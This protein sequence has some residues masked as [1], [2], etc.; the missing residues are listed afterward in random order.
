[1][2]R[3]A[4][5][6][7]LPLALLLPVIGCSDLANGDGDA[8]VHRDSRPV[9]HDAAPGVDGS[10]TCNAA[11]LL[12]QFRCGPGRQ[13]TLVS[14]GNDVGCAPAGA[15]GAYGSCDG[16]QDR[17]DDCG[18]GTLCSD[19]KT[20]GT[21]QCLPFCGQQ[22]AYCE[23][24]LCVFSVPLPGSETAYLCGP[25]DGCDALNSGECP[26]GQSCYLAPIGQDMTFCRPTGGIADGAPCTGDFTC[27]EGLTCFGPPDD[28]TCHWLCDIQS[29]WGCT[30]SQLCG[31]MGSERYGICF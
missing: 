7:V 10:T 2:L 25:A 26:L 28:A 22:G 31:D 6:I 15:I 19:A 23:G 13:C 3:Y 4:S 20:S 27:G 24:G 21:F 16:V 30:G 1:V 17:P 12:D 5:L 11:D 29:G 14:A 9:Q 18:L 8:G